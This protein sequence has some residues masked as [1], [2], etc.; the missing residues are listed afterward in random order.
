MVFLGGAGVSTE[1]GI[2]DY[3]SATGLYAQDDKTFYTG[4][5]I[6][7]HTFFYEHPSLFYQYYKGK[8][9]HREAKPNAAHYVLAK[10]EKE[11]GL[12]LIITQNID[13]LH[14]QAGSD[15]VYEMHGSM[16]QNYCTVCGKR[17]LLQ[18]VMDSTTWVPYCV[19][20]GIIRPEV[21]LYEEPLDRKMLQQAIQVIRKADLMIVGGTTLAVNPARG[22]V[23]YFRGKS[24]V[25]INLDETKLDHRAD[26]I[27]RQ[28]IGSVMSLLDER[29]IR[30]RG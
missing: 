7:S 28:K 30:Q 20:G 25:F 2:P 10:L 24:L 17:Y 15:H 14:Q 3:R 12:Q 9:I 13:G 4:A 27:I 23:K 18:D 8:L 22:L 16:H 6:L 1:S 11:F 29:L 26:L 5:T 19:C 21:V